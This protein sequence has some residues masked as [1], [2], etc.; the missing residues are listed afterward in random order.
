MLLY[1]FIYCIYVCLSVY[2]HDLCCYI[3][4]SVS[5]SVW[6]TILCLRAFCLTCMFTMYVCFIYTIV[7]AFVLSVYLIYFIMCV[8][9]L[10]YII[11]HAFFLFVFLIYTWFTILRLNVC[12]SYLCLIYNIT[13][14]WLAVCLSVRQFRPNRFLVVKN[15][16]KNGLAVIEVIVF[17]ASDCFFLS[18]SF[19]RGW[20]NNGEKNRRRNDFISKKVR[21]FEAY[22]KLTT[23]LFQ[24]DVFRLLMTF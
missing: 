23:N 5:L 19:L 11:V 20:F 10:D 12:L 2:L 4:L 21:T 15:V 8:C 17:S 16:G 7:Y 13:S 18:W 3:C 9:V 6:F 1:C 14:E 22:R 24:K